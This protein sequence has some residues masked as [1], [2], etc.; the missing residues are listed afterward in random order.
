MKLRTL[1]YPGLRKT[2][3]SH[4]FPVS[5]SYLQQT[6]TRFS[7]LIIILTLLLPL[8][9][10]TRL[11]R[12]QTLQ[13]ILSGKS[14]SLTIWGAQLPETKNDRSPWD[15]NSL[16]DSL[17]RVYLGNRLLKQ[18]L[19]VRNEL[20]PMWSITVG[21]IPEKRFYD[22]PIVV[23]ILEQDLWGEETIENIMIPLPTQDELA[24]V[25]T[26]DGK[27]VKPLIYQWV[28]TT[29]PAKLKDKELPDSPVRNSPLKESF[30]ADRAASN[31]QANSVLEQE[32]RANLLKKRSQNSAKLQS[33]AA[34]LYRAYLKAQFSGDQLQAHRILLRLALK[35]SQTRHGRKARRIM[36]LDGR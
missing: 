9:S 20:K 25:L 10:S 29:T 15:I 36:L 8:L 14:L 1:I 21:P 35:Y 7:Q 13:Q 3:S 6:T 34:S 23:E 30:T 24:Q 16:P 18:S 32:K 12:A 31:S 2:F 27:W 5:P 22:G 17:I 11:S 33:K 4:H 26:L 19:V 28:N